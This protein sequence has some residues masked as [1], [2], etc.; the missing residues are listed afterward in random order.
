MGMLA[1]R[2]LRADFDS[3]ELEHDLDF[4]GGIHADRGPIPI[5]RHRRRS[6]AGFTEALSREIGRRG[7]IAF[8]T[9]VASRH[10]KYVVVVRSVESG[11]E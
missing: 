8:L 4:P 10:F 11:L 1:P 5:M 9:I 2:G 6:W 3:W 7:R